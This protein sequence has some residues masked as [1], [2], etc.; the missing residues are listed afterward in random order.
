MMTTRIMTRENNENDENRYDNCH[1]N[2]NDKNN[3]SNDYIHEANSSKTRLL[4]IS[5]ILMTST[6]F[7]SSIK[8]VVVASLAK[9]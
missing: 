1:D 9:V 5:S 2:Y 7:Y 3:N 4:R 8:W 6:E